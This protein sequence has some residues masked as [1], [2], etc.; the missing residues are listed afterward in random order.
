MQLMALGQFVFSLPTLSFDEVRR[1]CTWRHPTNERV[2]AMPARQFVGP[3]EDTV[4]IAGVLV[5]LIAGRL[6]SIAELRAMADT[7]KAFALVG[8]TGEVFGAYV[9][10]SLDEGRS[11]LMGDGSPRRIEFSLTLQR[12]P[13]DQAEAAGGAEPGADYFGDWWQ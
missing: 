13:D 1:Q 7:G 2:G 9:I 6:G 10:E 4:T 11:M 8:G 5:P 12:K 3:G